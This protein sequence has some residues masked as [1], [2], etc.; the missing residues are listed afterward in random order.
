MALLCIYKV[1]TSRFPRRGAKMAFTLIEVVM[2]MAVVAFALLAITGLLPI[3]LQTMR[4]SQ[5]DQ[6]TGM[7]ANQ[8]R[9]DLQQVAFTQD[10]NNPNPQIVLST[11]VNSN[12]YYTVE[13]LKTNSA[14]TAAQVYYRASFAVTN[15]GVNGTAFG[16]TATLPSNAAVVTVN[17]AYPAP[18]YTHSTTFTLFATRQVGL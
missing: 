16:G 9:G 6:A 2:A 11:L 18:A 4:D 8:I 15:A 14:T 5:N 3:G 10:P 12:Y 7:I 1:M 17:L 13:G